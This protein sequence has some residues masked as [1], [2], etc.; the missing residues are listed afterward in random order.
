MKNRSTI[1]FF[2]RTIELLFFSRKIDFKE[3]KRKKKIKIVVLP[4]KS[5]TNQIKSNPC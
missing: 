2:L 4:V 5:E 3:Q 1:I